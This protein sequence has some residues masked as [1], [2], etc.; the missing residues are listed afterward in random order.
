MD[1]FFFVIK[2]FGEILGAAKDILM[3]E[4]FDLEAKA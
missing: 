1:K 3:N 2:E 4:V